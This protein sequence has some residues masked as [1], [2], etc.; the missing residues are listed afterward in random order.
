MTSDRFL[1]AVLKALHSISAF[2]KRFLTAGIDMNIPDVD[3]LESV[4]DEL[5]VPRDET[6]DVPYEKLPDVFCRDWTYDLFDKII[7]NG[8]EQE[9]QKFIDT[10]RQDIKQIEGEKPSHYQN[11]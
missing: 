3:L 1:I 9:C 4:L 2:E 7:Q 8:S 11:A 5:G 10:I 6:A